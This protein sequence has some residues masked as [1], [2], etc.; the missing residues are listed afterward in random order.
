ME[1][2]WGLEGN[3]AVRW[4]LLPEKIFCF[5]DGVASRVWCELFGYVIW[6]S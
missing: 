3:D 6:V 2:K 1:T 4:Y 5:G